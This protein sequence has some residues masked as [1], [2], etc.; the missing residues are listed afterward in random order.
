MAYLFVQQGGSC[1]FTDSQISDMRSLSHNNVNFIPPDLTEDKQIGNSLSDHIIHCVHQMIRIP[2]QAK[3][4]GVFTNVK[5]MQYGLNF[6]RVQELLKSYGGVDC[7]FRKIKHH[8]GDVIAIDE[9][10]KYG[11]ELCDLLV[12]D[13]PSEAFLNS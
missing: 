10:I 2:Y 7:W 6:G 1:M 3:R 8:F 9:L 13:R 5:I 11:N 4:D 12:I